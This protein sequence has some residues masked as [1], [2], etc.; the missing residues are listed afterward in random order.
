MPLAEAAVKFYNWYYKTNNDR[1]TINFKNKEE[2]RRAYDT[3]Y[4]FTKRRNNI[5]VKITMKELTMTV[6]R[7]TP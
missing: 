7:I 1:M 3:L 6:E 2:R 4:A 5:P